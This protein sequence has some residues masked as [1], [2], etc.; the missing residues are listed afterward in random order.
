[1]TTV[2]TAAEVQG[3]EGLGDWRV[4]A[5]RLHATFRTGTLARGIE[6]VRRVGE[7]ADELDHHPDL[8]VRYFRVH[9]RSVTHDAGGLTERDVRLARR[10]SAVAAELGL[11]AEP[12]RTQQV[13]LTAGVGDVAAAQ[14]F[15]SAVLGYRLPTVPGAGDDAGDPTAVVLADP[16]GRG[17]TVRLRPAAAPTV[18]GATGAASGE[19]GPAGGETGAAARGAGPAP[20]DDVAAAQAV[21]VDVHVPHDLAPAR[22]RAA[23]DAG[24]RLVDDAEAPA[25]WVLADPDG[26]RVRLCTWQPRSST[27]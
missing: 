1:M 23:L 25:R 12:G 2:L 13:G 8:D 27:G 18:S 15:W 17:P 14:A 21:I 9:V 7:I 4:V 11:T 16:A 6:L 26:T 22:L 10:I 24:G 19:T 20:R 5:G 3:R